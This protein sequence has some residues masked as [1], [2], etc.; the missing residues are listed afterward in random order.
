M[1]I[2]LPLKQNKLISRIEDNIFQEKKRIYNSLYESILCA[3]LPVYQSKFM[4][5]IQSALPC[6]CLV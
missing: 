3:M 2:I 5:M 6:K 4:S 1:I